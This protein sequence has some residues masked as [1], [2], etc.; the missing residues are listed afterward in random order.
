MG[1]KIKHILFATL[2]LIIGVVS[3][4]IIIKINVVK[5]EN[6]E[7]IDVSAEETT[8]SEYVYYGPDS[9]TSWE[10]GYEVAKKDGDWSRLPLTSEFRKKYNERDGILGNLEFDKIE[11]A[12]YDSITEYSDK[13]YFINRNCYFVISRGKEKIAY[14]YNLKYD[15]KLLNDVLIKDIC[16]LS[17][18]YGEELNVSGYSITYNNFKDSMDFL[19]RGGNDE[20]SVAVTPAFHTKYPYF[21][22]LFIHYS[23]LG[24]NKIEF[25]SEKSSWERK[26]AYFIVD[27]IYECIKRHYKVE[28]SLDNKGYLDDAKAKLV[29]EYPYDKGRLVEASSQ[30]FYKNSN[31]DYLKLSDNFR[32]KYKDKKSVYEGIDELNIDEITFGLFYNDDVNIPINKYKT[33]NGNNRWLC[34]KYTYVNKDYLDEVEILEIDYKGDNAEEAKE[35]YIKQYEGK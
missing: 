2:A 20:Q 6:F 30:V 21:L 31:W 24:V 13:Y 23:P 10:L 3:F 28:F 18:E 29:G 14:I 12:P 9:Y 17:N 35:A 4:V 33:K 26:E 8:Y 34:E 27:S 7:S 5:N 25:A 19:S 11:L 15:G 32:K 16:N 1:I 22:D